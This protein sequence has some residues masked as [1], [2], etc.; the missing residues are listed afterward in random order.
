MVQTIS[1]VRLGLTL[2]FGLS[3]CLLG[4]RPVAAQAVVPAPV[5]EQVATADGEVLAAKHYPRPGAVPVICWPGIGAN[6]FEFD[7]P[8]RSFARFLSARGYDVWLFTSRNTGSGRYV[9]TGD[10]SA[11]F[12]TLAIYDIDAALSY[13]RQQTGERPFLLGHSQG[14]MLSLAYLEGVREVRVPVRRKLAFSWRGVTVQTV[15]GLRVAAD[16]QLAAARN[17]AV[18]GVVALASPARLTWKAQVTP[19]TFWQASFWDYNLIFESLVWSPAAN[20]VVELLPVVPAA[21]LTRWLTRDLA[22]LPYVGPQVR[23]FLRQV[24]AQVGP[25]PLVAL[26]FRPGSTNGQVL[27]EALDLAVDNLPTTSLRQFMASVRRRDHL[28]A[29]VYDPLRRPYSYADGYG[30]VTAPA[31]WIGGSFDKIANDDT[32]ERH[33]RRLGSADKTFLR[34]PHGHVDVVVGDSAPQDVWLPIARWLDRRR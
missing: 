27:F 34:V 15:T 28:E 26:T 16:P 11:G 21:D 33:V 24:V 12:D 7:L 29:H 10:G 32:I 1:R 13:V 31:L 6:L 4:P 2:A 25:T 3:A 17:R 30:R 5:L 18:R 23:P 22:R 20:V 8:S 14:G 19:W 9:S